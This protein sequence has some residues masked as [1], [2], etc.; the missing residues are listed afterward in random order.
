VEACLIHVLN[1]RVGWLDDGIDGHVRS[2]TYGAGLQFANEQFKFAF[3]LSHLPEIYPGGPS[4][5]SSG[6]SVAWYF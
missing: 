1:L 5:T 3:D 6:M 4:V 2:E